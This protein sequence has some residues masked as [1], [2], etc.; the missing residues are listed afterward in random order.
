MV[1]VELDTSLAGRKIA[2][3]NLDGRAAASR[4]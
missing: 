4:L 3:G 1:R 2:T